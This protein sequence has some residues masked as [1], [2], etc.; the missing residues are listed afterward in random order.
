MSSIANGHRRWIRRKIAISYFLL[1]QRTSSFDFFTIE[2]ANGYNF[3][4]AKHAS[5]QHFSLEEADHFFQQGNLLQ[6]LKCY[7][8]LESHSR[9][10]N[11]TITQRIHSCLKQ[12]LRK[13]WR[14]EKADQMAQMMKELGVEQELALSHARLVGKEA[15][16]AIAAK[17][18]GVQA[19]L[20]Q[21]FLQEDL[22]SALLS[23][24]QWPE[25]K[26]IAE[27][28]LSLLKGDHER[29]LISFHQAEEQASIYSKIGKG[30]AYLIKGDMQQAHVHLE[31]LR[32]F[33]LRHFPVLAKAMSW[34]EDVKEKVRTHLSYYLFSASL[35]E[36]KRAESL[37]SS[38][39]SDVKGWIW[40]RIGDYSVSKSAKGALLAWDKAKKFNSQ[41]TLD[42]LKRRF[43][44]SCQ[45]DC[46]IV[47]GQAFEAFYR[48][49]V[50]QS[51]QDAK[52]F[53]EYLIFDSREASSFLEAKGLRQG[54][55]WMINPPPIE[56]QMFWFHIFYQDHIRPICQLLFLTPE[57]KEYAI[58]ETWEK[59]TSIFQVLD[60][61]YG[62]KESYLR[63]KLDLA[64]L[65][66]QGN[67]G[68]SIIVQLLELNAML[69]EELL[70]IYVQ[71][72]L[73]KLID[74]SA[75]KQEKEEICKEIDRLRHFWAYDYDLIRL[76]ILAN[77]SDQSPMDLAA[78]LGVHLSEPLRQVLQLQVA[79]DR[80]WKITRCRKLL[81]DRALYGR[82]QEA[83]WRLL[84][85]VFNP[86][87]KMP[88]KEL[89]SLVTQLAPDSSFKHKLFSHVELYGGVVP[90]FLL[91]NWL[92]EKGTWE[93][94]Y[95]LALY[96]RS[97]KEYSKALSSLYRASHYRIPNEAKEAA[98]IERTLSHYSPTF[99]FED[100]SPR[101]LSELL[102]ELFHS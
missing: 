77:D 9:Q 39:Q 7:Q 76:F 27:G 62:K 38:Q 26:A 67:F 78:L 23:L 31:S 46:S 65:Y 8:E 55:Q 81:P 98:N 79:I 56:L 68:R 87:L 97:Q 35:D 24:R 42:V 72:V 96:Y 82:D 83:D 25:L 32:P 95:H 3:D 90:L 33:A 47:P 1:I 29:A 58:R 61:E 52:E 101:E 54:E 84:I 70:P 40:L 59:W 64:L 50:D 63:Q 17:T 85:A 45:T 100:F 86:T 51:P 18:E 19:K 44:L 91:K 16:A 71:D 2:N 5:K 21:C 34:K 74:K 92:K 88:K 57:F 4:M 60:K 66:E 41:L 6:A 89:E 99:P 12:L 22:K 73:S 94:Y 43:L 75:I 37:L 80:G 10:P 13:Y 30:V 102:E 14:Q 48:K 15:V 11:D 36:L 20:A 28:W 69:K 49:L 93:P 53:V